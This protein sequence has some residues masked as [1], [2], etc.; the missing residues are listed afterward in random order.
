MRGKFVCPRAA[1]ALIGQRELVAQ[2]VKAVIHGC[3]RQHQYPR[4]CA[5][6]DDLVHKPRVAV[7]LALLVG[8]AAIAEI[9]RFIDHHKVIRRPIQLREVRS[10][11]ET[12][13]T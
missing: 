3:C 9:V 2:V 7:F 12:A 8:V 11:R 10:A 1:V 13:G 5:R 6:T 4:P